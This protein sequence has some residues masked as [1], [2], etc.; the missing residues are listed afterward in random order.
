MCTSVYPQSFTFPSNLLLIFR[1]IIVGESL[2][3]Y[4][5]ISIIYLITFNLYNKLI[6]SV[7]NVF[8]CEYA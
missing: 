3:C 8:I 2:I 4:T 5:N 6:S 1:V 7:Y